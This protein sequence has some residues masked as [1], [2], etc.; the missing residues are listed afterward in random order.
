MALYQ[1]DLEYCPDL[2]DGF[3]LAVVPVLDSQ[4]R[5]GAAF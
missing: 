1:N 4:I 2:G 5:R 3:V